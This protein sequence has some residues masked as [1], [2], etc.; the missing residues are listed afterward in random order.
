MRTDGPPYGGGTVRMMFPNMRTS[1]E[2]IRRTH[3]PHVPWRGPQPSF[4]IFRRTPTTFR[5]APL[6]TVI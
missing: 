4:S 5:F 3:V 6:P 2:N 1:G